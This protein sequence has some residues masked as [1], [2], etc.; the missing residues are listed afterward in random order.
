M[1]ANC[2]DIPWGNKQKSIII[3]T[4]GRNTR[5]TVDFCLFSQGMSSEFACI[6]EIPLYNAWRTF[7]IFF[8]YFFS[9]RGGGRGGPRR[10]AG[11]I[12]FLFKIPGRGGGG[13]REGEG[14]RGREGVCGE[15]G[16][17]LGGGAKYFFSG[18]KTSTKNARA[19]KVSKF[20]LDLQNSPQ[21]EGLSEGLA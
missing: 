3:R 6:S 9:V 14:P 21:K 1:H 16:T 8:I 11:E 12:G 18:S 19:E 15:L 13:F 4:K 5:I 10:Q 2:D 17:I 7:R 20:N